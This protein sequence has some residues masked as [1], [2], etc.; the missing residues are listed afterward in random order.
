MSDMNSICAR[1]T[2][3]FAPGRAWRRARAL[4]EM[5]SAWGPI[6]KK[7]CNLIHRTV[8]LRFASQRREPTWKCTLRL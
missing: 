5:N 3:G 4:L 6:D 7:P 2:G 1:I 8:L